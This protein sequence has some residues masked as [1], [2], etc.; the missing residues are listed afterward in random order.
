M[1]S[2]LLLL[3]AVLW[4]PAQSLASSCA[5]K[6][7][8]DALDIRALQTKLMVAALSC[9]EQQRYNQF[10]V[11]FDKH[12]AQHGVGV[13]NYFSRVYNRESEYH[14][15]SFVTK[16][17]NTTSSLSLETD[18]EVF[19]K[20]ARA[21]MDDVIG[22]QPEEMPKLASRAGAS[23]LHGISACPGR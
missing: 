12:L 4:L 7:E 20:T 17:A 3:I 13:R 23:D 1:R 18:E 9:G 15:N 19:C 2:A 10:M 14:Q 22:S 8:K 16:L 11:K 6:V 21:L 5:S